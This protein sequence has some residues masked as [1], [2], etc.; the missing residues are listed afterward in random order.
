MD[1]HVNH[2]DLILVMVHLILLCHRL[3]DK[4]FNGENVAM[5]PVDDTRLP[6]PDNLLSQIEI[7]RREIQRLQRE[8][9][10][11]LARITELSK[12]AG[13][14]KNRFDAR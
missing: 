10:E 2:L 9:Q 3:P 1:Y 6:S 8:N 13:C 4:Y 11:L 12:T 5:S 7:Q 14:T